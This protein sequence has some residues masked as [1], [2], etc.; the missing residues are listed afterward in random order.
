MSRYGH[1]RP[2]TRTLRTRPDLTRLAPP[3][4]W[5]IEPLTANSIN[6]TWTDVGLAR[7]HKNYYTDRYYLIKYR[8]L[9]VNFEVS[10]YINSTDLHQMIKELSP[11]TQYEFRV[12]IITDRMHSVFSTPIQGETKPGENSLDEYVYLY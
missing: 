11:N 2:A 1:S 6:L 12:Y 9:N 5:K 10:G 7:S 4:G 3:V 8:R